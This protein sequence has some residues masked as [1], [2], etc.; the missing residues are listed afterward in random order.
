MRKRL[1]VNNIAINNIAVIIIASLAIL[2][3]ASAKPYAY[4]TGDMF[5]EGDEST[6]DLDPLLASATFASA[7]YRGVLGS[8]KLTNNIISPEGRHFYP[9]RMASR[10]TVVFALYNLENERTFS[11]AS[12]RFADVSDDSPYFSAVNFCASMEYVSG[13]PDGLFRPEESITRAE[14]CAVLFRFLS[15]DTITTVESSLPDVTGDHWAWKSILAVIESNI[16]HGYTDGTF[17]PDSNLTRA[18]LSVILVKI[19]HLQSPIYVRQFDDVP[20]SHWA[21]GYISCISAPPI[22]E[23]TQ[24]EVEIFD[25][26][27][28]ERIRVG[29][30]SLILEPSLC[31]VAH[32]KAQDMVDNDY[33]DHESQY[34]GMPE[35]MMRVFGISFSRHGENIALGYNAPSEVVNQWISSPSHNSVMTS[36]GFTKTGVGCATNNNGRIYWVQ[37]FIG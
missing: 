23:P 16:M 34:W 15:L 10:G 27:N 33:F 14:M 20:E 37:V 7:S 1:F 28:A 35:E 19:R 12:V 30:D 11:G 29:V 2:L 21:Y 8:G 36:S 22:S 3:I 26:V 17:K 18:E 9:E 5:F 13:Y 31:E 24:Q 32:V 25:L 4:A 6:I